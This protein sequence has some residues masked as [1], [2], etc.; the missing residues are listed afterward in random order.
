MKG[1][2]AVYMRSY[3]DSD[4]VQSFRRGDYTIPANYAGNAFT[5]DE[6][7]VINEAKEKADGVQTEVCEAQ[8]PEKSC[9]LCQDISEDKLRDFKHKGETGGGLLRGLFSRIENGL[10]FD[11]ILLI[12]L[13]ILLIRENRDSGSKNDEIVILLAVLLLS[14]F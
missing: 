13:I 8:P 9:E 1:C 3:D 14:G 2:D 7:P 10:D 12:G 4:S 11:D 5:A 6:P